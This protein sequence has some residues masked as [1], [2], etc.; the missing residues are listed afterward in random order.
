MKKIIV[1]G[2][3]MLF[4]LVSLILLTTEV[5]QISKDIVIGGGVLILSIVLA[6]CVSNLIDSIKEKLLN[7]E[8]KGK[9]INIGD[10]APGEEAVIEINTDTGEIKRVK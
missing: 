3:A 8:T 4:T 7:K 10:I 9:G 1:Y 5:S 2:I 6:S